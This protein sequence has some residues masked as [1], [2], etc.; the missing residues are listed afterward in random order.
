[1]VCAVRIGICDDEKAV[2]EYL[3]SLAARLYRTAEMVLYEDG[4]QLL[5]E[6]NAPD[7]LLLDIQMPEMDGM[8]TAKQLRKLWWGADVILIFVTAA[9]E[10]VFDAFDVQAFQ[11]LVKPFSEERFAQ[12]LGQAAA[13]CRELNDRRKKERKKRPLVIT[14]GGAHINVRLEDIIYAEVYNR[15]VM[16]H[17]VAGDLEYY[18]RLKDLETA[19]EGVLFRTHRA[20]LVNFSYIKKYNASCIDLQRGQAQ[21]AKQHY[22]EF[23]KHYLKFNQRRTNQ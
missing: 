9:E 23:V 4:A 19:A 14:V 10:Y 13:R 17:T 15:K 8:E 16:L 21:I 18:G 7:I 5:A 12:V 11:Y 3:A 2:R 6:T 22:Q 1:M 20:Y